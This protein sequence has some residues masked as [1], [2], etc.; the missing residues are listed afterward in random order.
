[1]RASLLIVLGVV[2][3]TTAG[4]ELR[5]SHRRVVENA[6]EVMTGGS[7]ARGRELV[8]RYGCAAC[9][10][11]PGF[12][13]MNPHVGPPL[14]HFAQRAFVAGVAENTADNVMK[15][16]REPR[17]IAPGSAMPALGI[18]AADARDLTAFL[19]TLQ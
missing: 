15:F 14:A 1:M 16:V 12:R 11:I 5:R 18:S 4:V 19:Y 8:G 13:G 10:A 2:A 6:A 17:T 7:V 3:L 9:H